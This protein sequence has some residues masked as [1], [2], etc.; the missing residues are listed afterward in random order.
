MA[1][2]KQS[3][4]HCDALIESDSRFCVKCGSR[5]P[6]A[7]RCPACLREVAK[8]DLLC[9]GCG[10]SLVTK[11]PHCGQDTFVFLDKC[12]HCAGSLMLTCPNKRCGQL[13][14]FENAK[15]TACGKKVGKK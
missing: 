11:C 5:S 9:A 12:A 10:R 14:F 3:C 8:A 4:I 1:S 7:L 2:Y 6:F 13:V 15:C